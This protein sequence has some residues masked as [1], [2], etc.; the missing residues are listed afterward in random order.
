MF[1]SNHIKKTY[2]CESGTANS[3]LG[4]TNNSSFTDIFNKMPLMSQFAFFVN[5]MSTV[6]KLVRSEIASSLGV[7][8][9]YGELIIDRYHQQFHLTLTDYSSPLKCERYY[10][11]TN[12]IGWS[13]W[14]KIGYA[15]NDS[16]QDLNNYVKFIDFNNCESLMALFKKYAKQNTMTYV[17]FIDYK[18]KLAAGGTTLLVIACDW[19]VTAFSANGQRYYIYVDDSTGTAE[20]RHTTSHSAIYDSDGLNIHSLLKNIN[21]S[22]GDVYRPVYLDNGTFKRSSL[23]IHSDLSSV[24]KDFCQVYSIKK[25]ADSNNL[26][27][28]CDVVESD[29]SITVKSFLLGGLQP[30]GW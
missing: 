30:W 10:S 7:N 13:P 14:K 11:L 15:T 28:N 25:F 2:L 23:M 27:L 9:I 24:N 4:T 19:Y 1:N 3:V 29:G 21:T 16:S 17:G 22:V 12:N 20:W 5:D 6:G 8:D 26:V 18:S